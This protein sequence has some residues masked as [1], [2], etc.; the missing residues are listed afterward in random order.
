M[1]R[2]EHRLKAVRDSAVFNPQAQ[3]APGRILWPRSQQR[4][5]PDPDREAH[6]TGAEEK[7]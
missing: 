3:V 5:P 4:P 2:R 1:K 7:T 6:R